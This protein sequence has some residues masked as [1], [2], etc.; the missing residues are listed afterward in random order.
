MERDPLCSHERLARLDLE[1]R[2]LDEL[3]G[4]VSDTPHGATAKEET[5]I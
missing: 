1:D 3:E 5:A 2:L 4:V